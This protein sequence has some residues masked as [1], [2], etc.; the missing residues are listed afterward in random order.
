VAAVVSGLLALV[1]GNEIGW[2]SG[3]ILGLATAAV[4]L[5]V[6]F[7]WW[8]GR[9]PEPILPLRLFRNTT[10]SLVTAIGFTIG[11]ALFGAIVFLPVYLQ[12][13]QRAWPT[14]SGLLMSP[15]IAGVIAASVFAGRM[16]T[17]TGRYKIFPI[18]GTLVA[19]VGMLALTLLGSDTPLWQ[20]GIYMAVVGIGVGLCMQVL[21]II[22]QN[23]VA[24]SDMGVA[25]STSQFFRSLGGTFGTAIFGAVLSSRLSHYLAESLPGGAPSGGSTNSL[26]SSPSQ[27]NKLPPAIHDPLVNSFVRALG[28]VFL[29]AVP[30]LLI[31]FIL[32]CFV[33]ETRLTTASDRASVAAGQAR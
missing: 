17:R 21:V 5:T 26:L 33:R 28:D 31:G 7:V 12:I 6:A 20:A 11:F 24:M 10:F 8:E 13:V 9:A 25:T 18:V 19:A 14:K 15:M 4:V 29:T 2:T 1:R 16:V 23:N 22:T 30:V 32:A 3:E 27:I